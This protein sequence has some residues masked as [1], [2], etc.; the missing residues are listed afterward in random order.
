MNT[1]VVLFV[2]N[3]PNL[4]AGAIER[5][6]KVKPRRLFVVADGPRT[7]AESQLCVETLS[8][9]KLGINWECHLQIECSE[10][11][12]GCGKR[13]LSGLDWVFGQV[14]RAIVLEDDIEVAPVFFDFASRG[15]AH[16]EGCSE[17]RMICARNALVRFPEQAEPFLCQRGSIWGW[18]TW[19]DRWR[20]FREG[21]A[22][23]TVESIR[24]GLVRWARFELLSRLQQYQFDTRQW[25]SLDTWDIQWSIWNISS[26]GYSIAAPVNLSINHGMEAGAT[27]TTQADDLRGCYPLLDWTPPEE[28]S[29]AIY[30]M[31]Y[32]RKVTLFD[33]VVNYNYPRRWKLF[34]RQ[35]DR[36]P[37]Q[38]DESAW[39]I[40]LSPFDH[41]DET[42]ELVS[43]LRRWLSS[44]CLDALEEIFP[45]R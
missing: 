36:V 20:A 18:A 27:H 1:P 41:A 13:I 21:F 34:S 24:E 15:L 19:A 4:A 30:S 14:D 31:E 2:F 35:R 16:W 26:G 29:E 3:R 17:V 8:M 28:F 44:P 9:V 7:V 12:L 22:A 38:Y 23:A 45:K 39:R 25:E 6:R 10:R 42:S 37:M 40:M 32:D 43:H 11:N 5:L 33:L